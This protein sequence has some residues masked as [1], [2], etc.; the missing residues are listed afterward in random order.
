M[1]CSPAGESLGCRAIVLAVSVG[2]AQ[3]GL[4][5]HRQL[6]ALMAWVALPGRA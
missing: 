3:G 6:R 4:A 5:D 1:I 2:I